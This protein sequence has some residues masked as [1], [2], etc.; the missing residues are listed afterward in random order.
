MAVSES[1]CEKK[2]EGLSKLVTD[3]SEITS[4]MKTENMNEWQYKAYERLKKNQEKLKLYALFL[5]IFSEINVVTAF[6]STILG[7][8]TL[9]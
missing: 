5:K 6:I 9:L 8:F 4:I 7:W 3:N 2:M 1:D